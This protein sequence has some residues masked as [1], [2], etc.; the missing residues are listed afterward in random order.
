MGKGAVDF[1][2]IYMRWDFKPMNCVKDKKK[3]TLFCHIY[4]NKHNVNYSYDY[5]IMSNL[6]GAACALKGVDGN[7]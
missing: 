6:P 7:K 3:T 5:C 4:Q 1:T 2:G